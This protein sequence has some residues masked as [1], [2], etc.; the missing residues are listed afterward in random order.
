MPRVPQGSSTGEVSPQDAEQPDCGFSRRDTVKDFL[1]PKWPETEWLHLD[2]AARIV[3]YDQSF[4]EGMIRLAGWAHDGILR[5]RAASATYR[6][7]AHRRQETLQQIPCEYWA[8][9]LLGDWTSDHWTSGEAR[10]GASDGVTF[11]GIEVLARDLRDCLEGGRVLRCDSAG[12]ATSAADWIKR[13]TPG[14]YNQETGWAAYQR[15]HPDGDLRKTFRFDWQAIYG[16]EPGR[17]GGA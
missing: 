5:T 3:E 16:R 15:E 11:C 2:A 4:F 14:R 1:A 12:A 10:F 13:Q 6:D 8:A 7:G 17:P 9:D